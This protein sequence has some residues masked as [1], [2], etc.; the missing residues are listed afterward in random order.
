M[1]AWFESLEERERVMVLT[2]AVFVVVAVFW[3]GIW[4]PLD[5]GQRSVSA[6]VATWKVSLA[7]LRPLKGQIQAG[8]SSQP[9]SAGQDQSLIVI[10]DNTLRQRG[11]NTALQR[12]QPTPAGDGIRIEFESV[13]FDDLMLWL[14]DVNRQFGLQIQSGNFSS[15]SGDIPGRVNSSLTLQ[16]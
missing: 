16:R 1:R 9:V 11:L 10:V 7:E 15:A 6:R 14:G 2:A 8:D 12:S 3:F 5:S 4:T 13:A